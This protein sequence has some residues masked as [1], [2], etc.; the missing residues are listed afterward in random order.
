[1]H[2]NSQSVET[3]L[4]SLVAGVPAAANF[5]CAVFPPFV[6]L[7][8]T[9]AMLRDSG[10]RWGAQTL[11]EHESGAFTGEVSPT[12]LTDFDCHYV[13]VGHSERRQY[14]HE[15]ND[16][17]AQKFSTAL[18]HQLIPILCVGETNAEHDANLTMQILTKQIDAVLALPGGV[19]NFANAVIAYEPVW[20]IGSGKTATPEYAEQVHAEIRAMIATHD[21]AIA[22][23]LLILYGGSVNG[24]NANGLFAMPNIDGALVGGASLKPEEFLTICQQAV[25]K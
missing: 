22:D 13:L 4:D 21:Q 7:P 24:S 14:Y 19:S 6:F 1:M 2:G 25:E 20:A 17:V 15:T 18:S 23:Q 11:S 10:I 12:M 8:K 5:E 16:I 3:L 9:S